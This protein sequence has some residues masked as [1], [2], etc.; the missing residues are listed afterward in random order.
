M[1][2]LGQNPPKTKRILEINGD[3]P[4]IVSLGSIHANDAN[5]PELKTYAQLLHG[6]A[7]LAEGGTLPD[8]GGYSH[9]VMEVANRAISDI[10]TPATPDATEAES[11]DSDPS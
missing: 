11:T 9:V 3:H 2:Q 1:R 7:I 6:Q 8:P 5:A 10:S 4:F